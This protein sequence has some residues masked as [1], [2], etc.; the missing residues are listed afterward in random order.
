MTQ[1]PVT[2]T[3]GIALH[4]PGPL[5]PHAT[6]PTPRLPPQSAFLCPP[7]HLW[8][9]P[10]KT[11]SFGRT[12]RSS[13]LRTGVRGGGGGGEGAATDRLSRSH[14]QPQDET[15]APAKK[16][17]TK[18]KKDA[19]MRRRSYIYKSI[20]RYESICPQTRRISVDSMSKRLFRLS[21]Q[22]RDRD[23]I[24]TEKLSTRTIWNL[25]YRQ[26]ISDWEWTR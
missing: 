24:D 14:G 26:F 17:K 13:R 5:R 3:R 22:E 4:F 15:L 23:V 10:L 6:R 18:Q 2:C 9:G 1:C 12:E 11:S 16:T 8:F 20:C 25:S 7:H 19:S 21:I